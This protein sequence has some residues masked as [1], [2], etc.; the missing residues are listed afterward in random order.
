MLTRTA[1][2]SVDCMFGV[3]AGDI[4]HGYAAVRHPVHSRNPVTSSFCGGVRLGTGRIHRGYNQLAQADHWGIWI[5]PGSRVHTR[6]VRSPTCRLAPP[7]ISG[8]LRS[9]TLN[10]IKPGLSEECTDGTINYVY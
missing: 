7:L 9:L 3:G 4:S 8:R 1:L 10:Q 2:L 6:R 5:V